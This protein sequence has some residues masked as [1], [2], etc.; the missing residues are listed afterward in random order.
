M[1]KYII[2]LE[3]NGKKT[4]ILWKN[5]N[6]NFP[7]SHHTMGFVAFS[8]TMGNWWGNPCFFHMMKYTIGGESYG[9]NPPILWES[10]STNFP[11]SPHGWPGTMGNLWKNPCISHMM[12]YTIGWD[13][14]GRKHPYYGKSMS[15]NFS[16]FPRT[17]GFVAFYRT[18]G[19]WWENPC[20]SSIMRLVNFFLCKYMPLGKYKICVLSF[21]FVI[22]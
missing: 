8:C 1:M 21:F 3:S 20:T 18:L 17:M 10:M 6:T 16:D 4:P 5:M 22:W 11:G 12:T 2:E 7:G 14:M 19:N 13:L 15:I 9:E